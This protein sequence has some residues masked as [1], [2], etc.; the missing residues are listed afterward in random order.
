MF[1]CLE[2]RENVSEGEKKKKRL[3]LNE[4]LSLLLLLFSLKPMTCS[5]FKIDFCID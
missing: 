3:T 5:G 2:D 1:G 4:V